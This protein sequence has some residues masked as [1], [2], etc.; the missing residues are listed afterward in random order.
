VTILR[1]WCYGEQELV[2]PVSF[3]VGEQFGTVQLG[4]V[5]GEGWR[6]GLEGS[7]EYDAV[8]GD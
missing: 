3:P 1:Q 2:T 5:L 4:P 7:R 6:P 8:D